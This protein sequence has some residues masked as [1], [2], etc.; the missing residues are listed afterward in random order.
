MRRRAAAA[1]W[2]PSS[3]RAGHRALQLATR[4]C[5][6]LR[7]E[8]DTMVETLLQQGANPNLVL[9]EGMAPIH[10][11][12]GMEQE[13]GLR[14]L[15][16][17]LQHGGDPNARS[18]EDLTPLHVAASWGCAMCLR[19]L[20]TE[21]GDP[22]I[23]DQDRN[24]ALDLALEQGNAICA[25]I[26]RQ[27]LEGEKAS[28]QNSWR[29]YRR[30]ESFLS[31]VTD[32][33]LEAGGILR[34]C[35][36][37][38]VSRTSASSQNGSTGSGLFPYSN[39]CLPAKYLD[40]SCS[41]G[42]HRASASFL[43]EYSW[44]GMCEH[45]EIPTRLEAASELQ[46][47]R[48]N[49]K[50]I[51]NL[52]SQSASGSQGILKPE[53]E[54]DCLWDA[55]ATLDLTL[56]SS[57][58]DPK[59]VVKPNIRQ[60]LDV[61]SPDHAFLF[62]RGD[63]AMAEDL[64]RTLV[65]LSE[66]SCSQYLS[67]NSEASAVE[68]LPR[69]N[70]ELEA[71]LGGS[72][73]S[74]CSQDNKAQR[75]GELEAT[76]GCSPSGQMSH[77]HVKISPEATLDSPDKSQTLVHSQAS[78]ETQTSRL[79][80]TGKNKSPTNASQMCQ[81]RRDIGKHPWHKEGKRNTLN[82]VIPI[83]ANQ[84]LPECSFIAAS[85]D[86]LTGESG[87]MVLVSDGEV[88]TQDTVLIQRMP[89]DTETPG[90]S[91][92][93]AETVPVFCPSPAEE[94]LSSLEAKLRA[95]M[96]ATKASHSPLLRPFDGVEHRLSAPATKSAAT[97]SLFDED[98]EMPRRPRRVRSPEGRPPVVRRDCV[99]TVKPQNENPSRVAGGETG[100]LADTQ[101]I[102]V[103]DLVEITEPVKD[104]DQQRP[105]YLEAKPGGCFVLA[106]DNQKERGNSSD[107]TDAKPLC[108]ISSRD[109]REE[110]DNSSNKTDT[111]PFCSVS[112]R[113]NQ[114]EWGNSSDKLDGK[115]LCSA[116]PKDKRE[117][118]GHSTN[119][120]DAKLLCSVSPR[121]K[122]EECGN[123]SNEMDA[124]PLCFVSLRDKRE[125]W[126]NDSNKTD[127]KPFCSVS[128]RDN[129][130]ERGKMDAKPSSVSTKEA[131]TTRVSFSCMSLREPSLVPT[132][133][134]RSSPIVQ[135][136]QL[137]PGGRPINTNVS[138]PVE[139]L[140]VDDDEGHSLVERRVP[141]TDESLTGSDDTV[142]YD[143]RDCAGKVADG[144]LSD[145]VLVQ[146]LRDFGVNPGPVTG[147]TRK[148]YTKLLE[149]LRN[150]PRTKARKN[151]AGYSPELTFA[152]ETFQ[153]PDA[154]DD[155]MAL[156]GQFDR[157]DQR[158]KWR[159]GLLKSSFNYLLLDP[160][161]TQNLPFRCHFVSQAECFRTFVSAIFYVGKG[162]RSR[163]Y[164]HLYEALTHYNQGGQ[165]KPPGKVSPKVCH[166]LEIWESGQGVVS[167]HCFQNVVPVE[168]YTREAC[169]VDAIGLKMLTNMKKGDYYGLVAGWPLKRRRRLGV[170]L[171]HRAMQIF[172]A[173]GE[174]QLC[175]A[176]IRPP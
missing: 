9:P 31:T 105:F 136:S 150:D 90:T 152:L 34:H 87:T 35:G 97:S 69:K 63:A 40:E 123:S 145:E 163:P 110:W 139:Y 135:A 70:G 32:D 118:R 2:P 42:D 172:L 109:K 113:D 151:T 56:Y 176:D 44:N 74:D 111:K 174:R 175:P 106:K 134:Q 156:I 19:L 84:V 137:S 98:L 99:S 94:K 169:I 27:A 66:G 17:L 41:K 103:V 126:G 128:P 101:L 81:E 154:K 16:L 146:E 142:V 48:A 47:D 83:T 89:E 86:E 148:L 107:K 3:G 77:E 33:T 95:M 133:S 127:T 39:G 59:L 96:L 162:K 138:K 65:A 173:E 7:A 120:M 58:L 85:E 8:D 18:M 14:C 11:A 129:Q 92:E 67:C 119:Q 13:S 61:T 12:A 29:S 23:Q 25:R 62:S 130:K 104:Y 21:G 114:K 45:D 132:S 30:A 147:L 15:G 131:K 88:Q 53:C 165:G 24:T 167:M 55:N 157:L 155:E 121:D 158:Q 124:K 37:D 36:P 57:F 102:P 100:S 68:E 91:A 46:F 82:L 28:E 164:S 22:C 20:L 140:Y 5:E 143:W 73:S 153:I 115:P 171:L 26:L 161:V 112:P 125:D 10:L 60:G 79:S 72:F 160:R 80:F 144:P 75:Y 64:E 141:F 71:I 51:S 78:L 93:V 170:F 54:L 52:K 4:L 43:T 168:A 116:S 122:R 49:G 1:H 159:E 117:E 108:S 166:I 76:L 6:A 38:L 50:R 149:K